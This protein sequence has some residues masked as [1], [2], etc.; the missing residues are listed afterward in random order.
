MDV[1]L[2]LLIDLLQ[3]GERGS[4]EVL[5][6][7]FCYLGD[8]DASAGLLDGTCRAEVDGFFLIMVLCSPIRMLVAVLIKFISGLAM[9][10]GDL[11]EHQIKNNDKL[12]M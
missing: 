4:L 2:G 6:C 7:V 10:G 8:C 9:C 5:C 1:V 3:E 11:L 12:K